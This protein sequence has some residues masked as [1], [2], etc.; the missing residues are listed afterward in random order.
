MTRVKPVR[1]SITVMRS[2]VCLAAQYEMAKTVYENKRTTD[3]CPSFT[4]R[5]KILNTILTNR[6]QQHRKRTLFQGLQD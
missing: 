3:K 2:A 1:Q 6:I 5:Q 4:H